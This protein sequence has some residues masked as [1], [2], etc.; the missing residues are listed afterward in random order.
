MQ[1]QILGIVF[2]GNEGA[3]E[4]LFTCSNGLAVQTIRW[5]NNS[6]NVATCSSCLVIL[7]N[8]NLS[9]VFFNSEYICEVELLRI[10]VVQRTM[11]LPIVI[12]FNYCGFLDEGLPQL[13]TTIVE[14]SITSSSATVRWMLTDPFH[15]PETFTLSYGVTSGQLDMPTPSVVTNPTS[16]TYTTQL[17]LLQPATVYFYRIESRNRFESRVTGERSFT[18][19]DSSKCNTH[20]MIIAATCFGTCSVQ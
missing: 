16:Q 12:F 10:G 3:R 9:T 20:S 18:T 11:N 8:S 4:K 14:S 19:R 5:L 6:D 17:D 2:T 7:D 13:P 15:Q 1:I